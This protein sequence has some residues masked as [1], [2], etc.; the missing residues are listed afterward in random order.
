MKPDDPFVRRLRQLAR[1]LLHSLRGGFPPLFPGGGPSDPYIGVR[2]PRRRGP[3]GR[4]ASVA[5]LEPKPD[6]SVDAIGRLGR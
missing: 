2:E 1:R 6:Q 3:S 5:L 4:S